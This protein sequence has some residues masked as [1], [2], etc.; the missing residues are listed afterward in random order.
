MSQK[1]WQRK[2]PDGQGLQELLKVYQSTDASFDPIPHPPGD[3]ETLQAEGK[4]S[5]TLTSFTTADAVELGHL[6]HARLAPHPRP[7]VI[8]IS[9]ASG[10]TL[11]HVA[12]GPG[13]TPDNETWVAR[14][15]AAVLRFSAST[16]SLHIKFGADEARF[17]KTFALG[18]EQAGKYAI[19][20][21]GVPIKVQGV[22][23]V[24][25]VV[26]VSGLKQQEDHGVIVDVINKYWE[27]VV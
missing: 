11:F 2:G 24:V 4:D 10:Q 15:K 9:T 6:L 16:W 1:I 19:H 20:G 14:K 8:N 23:G 7:T 22:E 12:T 25:G 27:P 18:P 5:F 26:I 17:A 21:G 13:T 3:I